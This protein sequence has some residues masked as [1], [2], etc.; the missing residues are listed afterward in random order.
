M[1]DLEAFVL[2]HVVDDTPATREAIRFKDIGNDEYICAKPL[3][4]H[5]TVIKGSVYDRTGYIDRWCFA[6]RELAHNAVADWPVPSPE[7]YE[8]EGWHRHPC[9]GRRRPDADPSREYIDP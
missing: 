4:F 6:T 8:P 9:S 5:W 3:M 1:T 2:T 7:G